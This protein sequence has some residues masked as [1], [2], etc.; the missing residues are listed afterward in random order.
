[1]YTIWIKVSRVG[2]SA[3]SEY[4][5][6]HYPGTPNDFTSGKSIDQDDEGKPN[7][8]VSFDAKR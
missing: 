3:A 4:V 5:L 1:M 2:S 8:S 7:Y 6:L